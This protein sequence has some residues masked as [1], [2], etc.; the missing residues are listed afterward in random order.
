MSD[1]E[2]LANEA[3][4]ASNAAS[5]LEGLA[6]VQAQFLGK[7]SKLVKAKKA[8]GTLPAEDRAN[9]G[10]EINEIKGQIEQLISGRKA[11]LQESEWSSKFNEERLDLTERLG[12]IDRGHLHLITQARDELEDVFIGMG[13]SVAEG[14]EVET[15]WYN[16]EALNIPDWHPARGNFD[17]IF[18]DLGEPEEVML[19]SHTSPVQIRTMES[20]EPPIYIVAPGRTFRT[21]SADATH[22]PAFNQIEGLVIDKGITM[23][24]LAGTID[25]FV[26][27]FF[28]EEVKSR[29]RPSYFPFT[30]PSAEFDISRPD[31]SWLE[32]GGCGMVHPN[33]L[34]NCNIDPEVWQGFAFGFG[35][36]RLVSMRYQLDDIR[37][38]VVN[39][40]RFLR[41]F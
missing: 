17:T 34:R 37:E 18:V 8:L 16:F 7:K 12:S 35:I 2:N 9:A 11:V 38:L 19:R 24:D 31:G 15:A 4:E 29:L 30:E 36:D 13:Y 3:E 39:D 33:V 10:K 22:L 41:Q 6:Q 1:L 40:A 25:S 32:L 23:G 5:T 28:G 20:Q 27:A 21:D 14:P 26:H